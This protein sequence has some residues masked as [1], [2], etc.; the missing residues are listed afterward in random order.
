MDSALICFGHELHGRRTCEIFNGET[1]KLAS[2]T[3]TWHWFGGLG[4]YKNRPT[5]VGGDQAK[6]KVETLVNNE[7]TSLSAHPR[8]PFKTKK[9]KLKKVDSCFLR[10]WIA[11]WSFANDWRIL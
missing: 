9:T 1:V 6:G 2:E 8:Y 11:F 7:W 10:N 4:L 3:K 5:A